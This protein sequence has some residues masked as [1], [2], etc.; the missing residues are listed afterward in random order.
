MNVPPMYTNSDNL[1]K[2]TFDDPNEYTASYY[3]WKP[4]QSLNH[5]FGLVFDYRWESMYYNNFVKLKLLFSL[6]NMNELDNPNQF[7]I[8]FHFFNFYCN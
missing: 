1:H 3:G 8:I 7:I 6:Q 2:M 4:E 5:N